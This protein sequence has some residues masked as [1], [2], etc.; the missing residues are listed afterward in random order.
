[1]RRTIQ[2]TN[3]LNLSTQILAQSFSQ[4]Q[5]LVCKMELTKLIQKQLSLCL[6]GGKTIQTR[7]GQGH[8]RQ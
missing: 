8:Y 4:V 6:L 2:L 1:M 3:I 7:V 5:T